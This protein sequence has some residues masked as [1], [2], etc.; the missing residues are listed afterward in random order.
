MACTC[1][2]GLLHTCCTHLVLAALHNR[3][4]CV[5]VRADG[6]QH[7]HEPRSPLLRR[8]TELTLEHAHRPAAGALAALRHLSHLASLNARGAPLPWH[9]IA[10]ER[11]A[12]PLW[13]ALTRL[14]LS[15]A[16]PFTDDDVMGKALPARS[17]E[18]AA[19]NALFGAIATLPALR[20]ALLD[21]APPDRF[22]LWCETDRRGAAQ[23]LCAALLASRRLRALHLRSWLF[24]PLALV[25]AGAAGAS[26]WPLAAYVPRSGGAAV[27][28]HDEV[29]M[30]NGLGWRLM[31]RE[32][33]AEDGGALATRGCAAAS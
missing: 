1:A 31:C 11:G 7:E 30:V 33:L 9:E 22:G 29:A 4:G 3:V 21:V 17:R 13:P 19:L 14:E 12:Q 16:A 15:T 24:R 23:A 6:C 8:L 26:T 2:R 10:A 20:E 18:L 5:L 28:T 32:L 25:S 27:G